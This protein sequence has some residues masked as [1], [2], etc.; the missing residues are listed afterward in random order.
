MTAQ[1]SKLLKITRCN[2]L[3]QEE[4]K[5]LQPLLVEVIS[6]EVEAA[7]QYDSQDWKN[8]VNKDNFSNMH[9]IEPLW[10]RTESLVNALEVVPSSLTPSTKIRA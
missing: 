4:P 1:Q 6:N 10:K 8:P 9:H 7:R 3:T 2:D 5:M